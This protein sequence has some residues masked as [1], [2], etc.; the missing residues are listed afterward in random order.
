MIDAA[1]QHRDT[2]EHLAKS[3]LPAAEIAEALLEASKTEE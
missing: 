2:L 1:E 3:D